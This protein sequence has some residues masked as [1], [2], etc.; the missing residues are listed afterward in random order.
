MRYPSMHKRH[1][2]LVGVE[3]L[4]RSGRRSDI[5]MP[6][7]CLCAGIMYPLYRRFH[8][9]IG[10]ARKGRKIRSHIRW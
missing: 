2:F 4:R 7:V 8:C 5:H 10:Y 9:H 1:P 3:C 6:R